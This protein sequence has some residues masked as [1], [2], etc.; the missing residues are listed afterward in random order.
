MKTPA[1]IAADVLVKEAGVKE[2]L[3]GKA[4]KGRQLREAR[5]Y[6]NESG[7][8]NPD[9]QRG[10]LG[11]IFLGDKSPHKILKARYDQGG[12]LGKGGI[13]RGD[14]AFSPGM[15]ENWAKFRNKDLGGWDRTKG[16]LGAAGSGAMG[17]GNLTLGAALPIGLAAHSAATG[18]AAGAAGGLGE[19]AGYALG[20]PFGIAGSLAGG[21]LG[22][23]VGRLF[24]KKEV[25]LA[26][27]ELAP[28]L[29]VGN[30]WGR[31]MTVYK[32]ASPA[33]Q[34]APVFV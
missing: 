13:I 1:T 4:L 25:Q 17:A 29:G 22:G 18:D 3:F 24:P 33:V 12:I 9:L 28:E 21:Y 27:G 34:Q 30:Q 8:I 2:V 15:K 10:F 16:L 20:G 14:F 31:D 11:G 19:I 26:P 23:S 7:W 5:K 32:P 6:V